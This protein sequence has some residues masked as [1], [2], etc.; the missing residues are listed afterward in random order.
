[1]RFPPFEIAQHCAQ[2]SVLNRAGYSWG[3]VRI[4]TGTPTSKSLEGVPD[5][6]NIP[7][8]CNITKLFFLLIIEN[9]SSTASGLN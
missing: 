9:L 1:M 2:K 8:R 6:R 7:K 5:F 4:K 3:D